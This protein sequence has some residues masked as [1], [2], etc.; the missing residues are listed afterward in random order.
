MNVSVERVRRRETVRGE[1]ESTFQRLRQLG[2]SG[3]AKFVHGF[4]SVYCLCPSLLRCFPYRVCEITIVGLYNIVDNRAYDVSTDRSTSVR[5]Q[6][7][8]PTMFPRSL[9]LHAVLSY[10]YITQATSLSTVFEHETPFRS[11]NAQSI[12]G[13]TGGYGVAPHDGYRSVGYYVVGSTIVVIFMN[14][15]TYTPLELGNIWSKAQS[16]RPPR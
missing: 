16:T 3:A 13:S 9:V 10:F 15:D 8:F 7:Y 11:S 5:R 1:C 2:G 12:N 6:S 4:H 14:W